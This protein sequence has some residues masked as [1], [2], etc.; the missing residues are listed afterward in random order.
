MI[1]GGD[2]IVVSAVGSQGN[3]QGSYPGQLSNI[4]FYLKNQQFRI[5]NLYANIV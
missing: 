4:L 3:G 5:Y 2:C 1:H